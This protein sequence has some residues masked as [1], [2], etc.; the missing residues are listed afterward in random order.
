[1]KERYISKYLL[2]YADRKIILL[3]GPRQVGKTTLAKS[4]IKDY[5]YYNYDSPKDFSIFLNN[6]WNL[7]SELVIFDEL[8]KMNKWKLWLKGHFDDDLLKKQKVLVTGSAQLDLAKKVGDSLAGR[9][10][11]Y[12]LN[13]LDLK[14]L[15]GYD[16]VEN[17]YQNLISYSGFPE[18]FFEKDAYFYDKWRR[19][20]ADIILRQDLM[21]VENIKDI[22]S[23][24]ILIEL[25]SERIGSTISVN[26]LAEDLSKDEKTIKKWIQ[27]LEN[28]YIIF[29]VSPYSKNISRSIKKASKYYFYDSA[30]VS[31]DESQKLEN[32]VALSLKKE[33]EYQTDFFGKNHRLYFAKLKDQKEIDFLITND[34]KVTS[35]IEVKLS[36]V[37]VSE[38]FKH[39]DKF[40]KDVNKIQ[41]VKN[42]SRSFS[43]KESVLVTPALDYLENL[44]LDESN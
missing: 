19:T 28:L 20:H 31:G 6:N 5:S 17:N 34:K 24:E 35:L 26:S 37:S 15:K 14:E 33:I 3:S 43:N 25:L 27:S 39:F 4:L 2:K 13:P 11:S 16:K 41:L 29:K 10:F 40:F 32:L 30:R 9:Y 7:E 42:M 38:N 18:P 21:S 44:N 1:M 36:N 22:Q 8:H 23:I 12:R